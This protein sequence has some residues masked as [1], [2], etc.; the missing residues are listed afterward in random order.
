L[1]CAGLLA[2]GQS[3]RVSPE[4]YSRMRWR[5]IGP[6]GNRTDAI[7]GVPGDPLTYYAGAASGGIWKTSDGG[8]HWEPIFDDQP[9]SSIGALAV[10]PSDPNVVWAGTGEPFIRSHISV[11]EGIFKSTD[12]GKSW[13]RMGLEK[14]GRI[15]RVIVDP[16][17]PDVVLA[18][19]LGHAYGPQPE[20]GVFR[21]S[22]GG[23]T[24]TRVLFVD[25]NT[26]CSDMAM[27]PRNPR[28]LFAGMWQL[29][30]HTWGRDSGGPGSGLFTS[31]DGGATWI[32]LTGHGLPTKPV[33]K[34]AVAIARTNPNRVYAM[35][36]TGD[37]V[38]WNGKDTDTGQLWRSDDGGV[39]WRMI[40]T[41]R[42]AMGRAHYYSRMAVA[43]DN[44]NE[45]YYLTASFSK[46]IDAGQTLTVP[47]NPASPGG[48]NHDMW[49]DPANADRMAVANDAGVSLSVN[50]GRTWNH[51]R[52]PIAQIYHVTVDN[53]IPYYVYGNKQDGPSY[54]GP[55]NSRLNEGAGRGGGG[56][57]GIIPRSMWHTVGGGES[58]WATPDPA[59]P[60][61][62]WSTAS[63]SGSVGGIV[64]RY[65]ES[66]RQL[67]DVEIWPDNSNGP[68]ADVK[69]RFVWDAPLHISPH[70][71]NK[72]Y[73]GSQHVHQ[74]TDGGQSWQEISPDLTLNDKSRQQSSGGLTPDNIGVEYFDVVYRIAE[75][76]KQ[77]GVIWAGTN[78]GLVQLTRDAGKTW[79]NVTKNIPNLPQFGTVSSIEASRYDNGT[80]YI[81]VDFHQ[82]NNRDPFVYKTTDYGASWKAITNGIPHSMLSYAHCVREDPV[83]RG[84]LYLG[85][86]NGAYVSFDDGEN[87][88]P[89]QMNLPH[90]PV[91]W[92]VVQEHFNDLVIATYGRGFWILDDVTPLRALTAQT[93]NADAQLFAPRPAYRF[94]AIT[95]EAG[96]GEDPTVGQNPPYGA[97]INYYLKSAATGPVTITIA[98]AK[99]QTLRTLTAP[100]TAGVNRVYWDLRDA[101]SKGVTYR[102]SPLYAPEV[103]L[104][105]D[106]TREG[107]GGR[108]TIL[109]PP[110]TYTVKLSVGGKEYTQ[111]LTVRKDPNSAGTEADIVAQQQVLVALRRDLDAAVDAVNSAELVRHQINNL[112]N[113][114]Q[115]AELK[116]AA[117]DLDQKLSAAESALV[118]LRTTGRGQDG[119][120]FGSRLVQKIG[121]L[122]N[123]MAGGDFKPTNQH[124]AVQ[125]EL[126]DRL[127]TSQGQMGD[128][129]NRDVAA[130]ND[131]LKRANLP[132]VVTQVPR[133]PTNQ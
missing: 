76:P 57:G 73:V 22:D 121:Y 49:I 30:I 79:T 46:S 5:Y 13:A 32:R 44:E 48:D 3:A 101:P 23:K 93:M 50:R 41:D 61:V 31:H 90:A 34:V 24:W 45:T 99:G 68:A 80:A 9:V 71:R 100:R 94:R 2:Q 109:Q 56:G 95:S 89:L 42:N 72:I 66:R 55:S 37:G 20:R 132:N 127:K 128:V 65:E 105:P 53:Q 87:W 129:M 107:G 114:I 4:V 47:E 60:N 117:D 131:M 81:T 36:E 67:R 75:S 119:V 52:L 25:E 11:G 108:M 83:R 74:T 97:A 102:T 133:R 33:G 8:L 1:I 18:C 64:V 124:L 7:A 125:K 14:T 130:F 126:E 103:R 85:T 70:D 17:N 58:G 88:E 112:K 15:A 39:N 92:L 113:I 91:Y 27:D 38:P 40:N 63:G 35:I 28:N 10:A 118:E 26:G 84:L 116:K 122:A 59:D 54:R 62:I 69:Y 106:G 19:A 43:T 120:R 21:T 98:D 115:D 111:P 12:A 123:G 110:G 16:A 86:E 29:E 77:A 104:G 6:E 51:V 96:S 78:D 82:V